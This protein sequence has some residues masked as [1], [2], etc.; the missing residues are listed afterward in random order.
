MPHGFLSTMFFPCDSVDCMHKI[1]PT[2]ALVLQHLLPSGS[3]LI[4]ASSALSLLFNPSPNDKVPL[5]ETIEQWIKRGDIELEEAF[6]ASFDQLADFITVTRAVLDKG[7]DE[8]LRTTFFQFPFEQCR[9]YIS[10]SNI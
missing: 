6:G 9:S 2:A 7:E 5:F 10:H 8:Q 4:V 3:E 1:G